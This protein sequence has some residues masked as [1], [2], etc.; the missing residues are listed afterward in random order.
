MRWE[1][2]VLVGMTVMFAVPIHA[3][4]DNLHSR[5]VLVV[6][7]YAVILWLTGIYALLRGRSFITQA[8]GAFVAE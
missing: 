8:R 6:S 3:M 7:L 5:N 4:I 1:L 2:L